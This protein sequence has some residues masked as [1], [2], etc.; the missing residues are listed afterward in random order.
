MHA[1]WF[2]VINEPHVRMTI[3]IKWKQKQHKQF[4]SMYNVDWHVDTFKQQWANED[5]QPNHYSTG[6][7][8]ICKRKWK[9]RVVSTS[10]N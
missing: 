5:I 4:V 7:F 2:R 1:Y 9:Y 10:T 6:D 3:Y 8:H